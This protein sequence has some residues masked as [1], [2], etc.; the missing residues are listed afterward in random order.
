MIFAIGDLHFDN[1]GDKPMG[2]F[3]D[4]WLNHEEKI[5][6]NWRTNIK[7]DDLVLLAGDISW[8]LKLEEAYEDLLKI[9]ELPGKK[10]IIKGNHDYWWNSLR[11]LNNLGLKTINFL[12]N[13]SYIYDNIGIVG[14]RGWSSIDVDTVEDQDYKVFNRELNRLKLSL[15]SLRESVEKIIVVL[16]YPPFNIDCSPNGFID[17]VKE[18]N[19]DICVYGHLHSEGHK[20][21]VEGVVEG[22]EVHCISSDY[23][24]FIPKKIL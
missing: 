20:Y 14:T 17:I 22:I 16:H 4:N 18:Y 8:A 24:D 3:G 11:K 5:I 15:D 21:A 12:Q 10:I 2:I 13:N 9:D 6:D 1:T 19:G 7:E 23:I